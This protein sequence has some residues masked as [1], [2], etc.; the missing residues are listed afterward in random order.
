VITTTGPFADAIRGK[1]YSATIQ[2]SGGMAPYQFALAH[3][4]GNA[5]LDGLT[6]DAATG[7]I[8]GSPNFTGKG[9][10]LVTVTDSSTAHATATLNVSIL[11]VDQLTLLTPA[12]TTTAEFLQVALPFVQGGKAPLS[13]T[14]LNGN[15]P[16]GVRLDPATGLTGSATTTG[17]FNFTVRVQDALAQ[18]QTVSTGF[19]LQV[20]PPDLFVGS[21]LPR[22]LIVNRSV[23]E[24]FL[25]QGGTPPYVYVPFTG[26]L[27]VGVTMD[28]ATGHIS[29]TP[30]V[31]GQFN[32]SYRV[33]DSAAVP[34][35]FALSYSGA[36]VAAGLGRND[37]PA[38][39]KRRGDG[40]FSAS[41][42]P[43]EDPPQG[44]P[45]PS[46]HDYYQLVALAGS[47][48]SITVGA[49]HAADAPIDPVLELVDANGHRLT[50]CHQPGDTSNQF[51]SDCLN[52]DIS[53]SPPNIDSHLDF[54]A[55]T[56]NPLAT[57]YAHVFDWRGD[58]RPDMNYSVL[59]FN[60]VAPLV[61]PAPSLPRSI[62]VNNSFSQKLSAAGGAPVTW[63]VTS[64]SLPPGMNLAADGTIA[65][66]P[67][68]SGDFPFTATA[69]DGVG[70]TTSLPLSLHV[71]TAVHVTSP[72]TLPD[73]CVGQAYTFQFTA[74]G[75]GLPYTWLFL[76]PGLG[77]LDGQ[78]GIITG[79]ANQTGTLNNTIKVSSGIFNTDVQAV[80]LTVRNCP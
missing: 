57:F 79:L 54:R 10:G 41:L 11:S 47:V 40:N 56:G 13:Y 37:T 73:A 63:T 71:D 35:T 31:V 72:A 24:F 64:G 49:S 19:T 43:F 50:T 68:A 30:T 29:G 2:A 66:S 55:P 6:I 58:A 28:P 18:P 1:A 39:A 62:G 45:L 5:F 12:N 14:L 80:T 7:A 59:V 77:E 23:D 25:A 42:S 20:R 38:T 75:G 21:T 27:P 60:S 32:G 4:S 48:V 16:A 76:A 17:T 26:S 34:L 22:Q 53:T 78:T 67:T 8:A 74:T 69:T 51:T 46:D 36:V 44:V 33:H 70:Q 61:V 65:G 9:T 52:D 15:L 3:V